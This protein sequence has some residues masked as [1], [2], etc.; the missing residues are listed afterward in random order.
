MCNLELKS[1]G[2]QRSAI[3]LRHEKDGGL[4]CTNDINRPIYEMMEPHNERWNC[5]E[6]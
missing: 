3:L 4:R 1:K 2:L 6:I 5:V